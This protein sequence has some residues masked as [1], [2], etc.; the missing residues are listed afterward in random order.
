MNEVSNSNH[1]VYYR[2]CMELKL[3][4]WY[5]DIMLYVFAI[6]R[7]LS[8]VYSTCGYLLWHRRGK[9]AHERS[10]LIS[11]QS[12]N[13]WVYPGTQIRQQGL[14]LIWKLKV[15]YIKCIPMLVSA[16]TLKL[17]FY[18]AET[19]FPQLKGGYVVS[20][21]S[22]KWYTIKSKFTSR[23]THAFFIGTHEV[24]TFLET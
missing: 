9:L 16:F 12:T 23:F 11:A 3:N 14:P 8:I 6:R 7:Y 22:M 1:S 10:S 5:L 2:L 19:L 20:T 17:N 15:S 18:T 4:T 21:G 24:K 13:M